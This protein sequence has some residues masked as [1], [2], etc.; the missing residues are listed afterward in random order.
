M[1]WEVD[2]ADA[3]ATFMK[4][5]RAERDV[6]VRQPRETRHKI[7]YWFLQVSEYGLAN[8]NAKRKHHPDDF[9]FNIGF[10]HFSVILIIFQNQKWKTEINSH[11][12]CG[13]FID[14]RRKRTYGNFLNNFNKTFEFGTVISGLGI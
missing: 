10:Q 12:N 2:R 11:N 13:I 7:Y 14:D 4:A 9:M 6:Y 8:S 5:G 3:T 1:H